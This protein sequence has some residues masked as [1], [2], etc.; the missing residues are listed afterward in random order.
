MRDERV[1]RVAGEIFGGEDEAEWESA[2]EFFGFAG[3]DG[4]GAA[5]FMGAGEEGVEGGG[6]AEEEEF[7]EGGGEEGGAARGG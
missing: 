3:G 4:A 2:K 5:G 1:G 6:V 7:G